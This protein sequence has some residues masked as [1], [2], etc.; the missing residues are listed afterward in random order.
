ME[1]ASVGMKMVEVLA[2]VVTQVEVSA[3]RLAAA[4]MFKAGQGQAAHR[5]TGA[6]HSPALSRV[7][8]EPSQPN[9]TN[10]SRGCEKL[11]VA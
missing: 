4:A 9:H 10:L 3:A 1:V 6:K 8:H 11:N 2:A 7:G 5:S